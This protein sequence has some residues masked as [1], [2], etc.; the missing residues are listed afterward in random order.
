MTTEAEVIREGNI[1]YTKPE[2]IPMPNIKV[3]EKEP[4]KVAVKVITHRLTQ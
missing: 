3:P 1:P 4:V 2:L